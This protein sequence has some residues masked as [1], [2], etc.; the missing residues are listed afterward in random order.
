[1]KDVG[2]LIEEVSSF[3][4]YHLSPIRLTK[5]LKSLLNSVSLVLEGMSL[6]CVKNKG[7][8]LSPLGLP[9]SFDVCAKLA[10]KFGRDV[11]I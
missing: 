4:K 5:S 6:S 8:L 9:E 3:L 10:H 1:M 7:S 11:Y 2:S